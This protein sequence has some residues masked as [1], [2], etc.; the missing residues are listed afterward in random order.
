MFIQQIQEHHDNN[1]SAS[2]PLRVSRV[3]L[4]AGGYTSRYSLTDAVGKELNVPQAYGGNV[5]SFII[6][7]RFRKW[8]FQEVRHGSLDS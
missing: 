2:G 6:I 7:L 3:N 1:A 5:V 8:G 4:G